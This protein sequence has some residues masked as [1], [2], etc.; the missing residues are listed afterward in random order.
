VGV[1]IQDIRY[2]LR[3]FLRAPGF[4]LVALL[5]LALGIGGTTAIFSVVDGV[6]LRPLP[7][8]NADR[9][10]R[11]THAQGTAVDAAY[12][13]ADFLDIKRDA[14]KLSHVAAYREDIVDLTGRGEPVR[15]DGMQTTAGFFDVMAAAP[16]LGRT[17]HE[18]T[19]KA[20]ATIC[21]IGEALWRQQFG[22]DPSVIG[23]KIRLN[24]N[25]MEIIGVVPASV[26]HPIQ[27]DVWTLSPLPVPVS[28]IPG[29]AGDDP[30]AERGVNYFS[31]VATLRDDATVAEARE[32][33]RGISA[34]LAAQFPENAGD[35]FGVAPLADNMI[36]DVRTALYV[37]LGA[38]GFVLLIACANVAGLLMARGTARRREIAVR[39]ALGAGRARLLAQL[40]TESLV[41]AL[42]GGIGGLL[43]GSWMLSAL[44]QL[45][46]EN[47]P[48]LAEVTLDWRIALL[49]LAAT[50]VVGVI[51]GLA[52]ALQA[53]RPELNNDLK[54]GGRSGTARTGAR[55]VLVV[56]QV[57]LALVLLIG[58]GLMLSSLFRL[59]AVDP[60]FRTTELV[61]VE[62]P[63]PQIRYSEA[64]QR[65]FYGS[66]IER[67][68]ANPVTAQ[69]ALIFPFPLRGSNAQAGL[70]V[71]GQ[72]QRS[73]Q[74]RTTAELNMV[75]PG[76][77]Q[78]AG[79]KLIRGRDFSAADGP[80]AP[81]VAVI[82][83]ATLKDFGDQDPIGQ[84]INLGSPVTVIGVVSSARRRSLDV[85]PRAAVY[86]PYTQLVLPYMGVSI[87][88]AQGAGP[89][90]QAVKA[91]VAQLDPDLP[92][93]EV[94]TIEQ[95]IDESTG[96]PRFRSFL[97]A[98]FAGLALLLAA[99]GVYG[100]ISFSVAQRV[101]EIGVRLA[102]GANPRQLFV[103]VIGGGLRLAAIGVVL[104]VI[105]AA[106]ATRMVQGL[107]FDTNANDPWIY[108]SL[109]AMLL[110]MAALA[111]YVPARRA[112]RVDPM[113]AL[114]SE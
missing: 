2:A 14:S 108:A 68:Q 3:S 106:A 74:D 39:T 36:S 41:L 7:Y 103:H 23:T 46:P 54:E 47:L 114:R 6:L 73:P 65:Q 98:S 30:L 89:V 22:A 32:E 112:M 82:S 69:S 85:A 107:L 99:V 80:D 8:P 50:A 88:T 94:R 95:I 104:G 63:L 24:G 60:G 17:Y 102:L 33:L 35:T 45:A 77:F 58:A 110:A 9:I 26:R 83:E 16:L 111:C 62:L 5:T 52:P 53:S 11:L 96:Q 67:L 20:G 91:A 29:E 93:G 38:V 51:F 1:L 15:I 28:P 97:L 10:V 61:A 42:G 86:L 109:S 43:L 101:P 55:S 18:A 12:S 25:P 21:V 71:V 27:A 34:R 81:P 48:R 13:A 4:T 79:M 49:T 113:T 87:R 64:Q 57:A 72:P 105:V 75:S 100:L 84:Q 78:T 90:L 56:A 40:L 31:A 92:V 37:L 70:Q 59:R 44:I 19:D 76:Y 66:V